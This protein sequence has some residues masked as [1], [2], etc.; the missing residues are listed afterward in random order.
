[1]GSRQGAEAGTLWDPMGDNGAGVWGV[2]RGQ[3]TQVP[4]GH[5]E[6]RWLLF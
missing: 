1:M 4:K 3:S 6:V 2:G 5:S